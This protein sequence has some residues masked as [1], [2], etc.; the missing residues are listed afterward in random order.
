MAKE[1]IALLGTGT[2]GAPIARHLL[3]AGFPVRAWNRT[4]GRAEP[5][6][7]AGAT[8]TD[9]PEEA[10]DGATVVPGPSRPRGRPARPRRASRRSRGPSRRGTRPPTTSRR[11]S[12]ASSST[13]ARPSDRPH[14]RCARGEP[15][16]LEARRSRGAR[17]GPRAAAAHR[18]DVERRADAPRGRGARGRGAA[19]LRSQR[20]AV[21]LPPRV[22]QRVEAG[23]RVARRASTP[24]SSGSSASSARCEVARAG[25]AV[26][27]P[28][29]T[30]S[31]RSAWTPASVRPAP[32]TA[33][34]RA[35]QRARAPP[36][37]RACTCGPRPGA[38]SPRTPRRRTRGRAAACARGRAPPG[39]ARSGASVRA[40]EPAPP[41]LSPTRRGAAGST[42]CGAPCGTSSPCGAR[43]R[44]P[45]P[46][47]ALG[48]L[49]VG[50][51]V[52]RVLAPR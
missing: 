11:S 12:R 22:A 24:T 39:R 26:G 10:V 37:P 13:S 51:R 14:R 32:T 35:E 41:T 38:A 47:E 4:R 2:M 23:R 9:T 18:G 44:G 30:R 17:G 1:T 50:E 6:A 45:T 8:V 36:R 19:R 52:R 21:P 43:S 25:S 49:V 7:A 3:E 29:T 48:D 31:C 16:R 42:G 46:R 40:P 20:V 27:A 5:L 28:R 15:R 33:R 34:R